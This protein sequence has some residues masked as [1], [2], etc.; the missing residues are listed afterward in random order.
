MNIQGT[1]LY[2]MK[3]VRNLKPGVEAC[4]DVENNSKFDKPLPL[5]AS[6]EPEKPGRAGPY[7]GQALLRRR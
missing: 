4:V 2:L 3:G 7:W 6:S 1:I 5:E